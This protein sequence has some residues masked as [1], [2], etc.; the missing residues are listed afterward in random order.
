[1]PTFGCSNF[2]RRLRP[3]LL[4][5]EADIRGFDARVRSLRGAVSLVGR[6]SRSSAAGGSEGSFG[7]DTTTAG[8]GRG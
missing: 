6:P 2:D 7:P 3:P 1:M 4:L 8:R 5:P